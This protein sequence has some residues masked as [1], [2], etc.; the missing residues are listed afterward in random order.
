M[1]QNCLPTCN[2]AS[3]FN[4]ALKIIR[5]LE[6][7]YTSVKN[8]CNEVYKFCSKSENDESSIWTYDDKYVKYI[9]RELVACDDNDSLP[10]SFINYL[11]SQVMFLQNGRNVVSFNRGFMLDY[12]NYQCLVKVESNNRSVSFIG[13][14][15]SMIEASSCLSALDVAQLSVAKLCRILCPAIFFEWVISNP[16]DLKNHT[17]WSRSY[18]VSMVIAADKK[19]TSPVSET[20]DLIDNPLNTMFFGDGELYLKGTG[21]NLKVAY[22]DNLLVEKMD[23]LLI[24]DGIQPVSNCIIIIILL[25]VSMLKMVIIIIV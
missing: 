14:I 2:D 22:L 5:N 19:G 18:P 3:Q 25:Q 16:L 11:Q 1:L 21:L 7:G 4:I 23:D 24:E 15:C 20:Q 10:I 9:G 8:S 13:R 12:H 17:P 6:L